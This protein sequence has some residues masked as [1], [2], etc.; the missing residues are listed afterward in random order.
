VRN[1]DNSTASTFQKNEYEL[2]SAQRTALVH[3]LETVVEDVVLVDAG[4]TVVCQ[5]PTLL[6]WVRS[7]DQEFAKEALRDVLAI[8]IKGRRNARTIELMGPPQHSLAIN[9]APVVGSDGASLGAVAIIQD[10]TQ[11]RYHEAVTSDF[12]ASVSHELKTPIGALGLLADAALMEDDRAVVRDL[13]ERMQ[14]ETQ[15]VSRVIDD[16]LNLSNAD[17]DDCVTLPVRTVVEKAMAGVH[18]LAEYRGIEVALDIEDELQIYGSMRHLKSA[19]HHLL[20]NAVKFSPR[21]STVALN[22]YSDCLWTEIAITNSGEGIPTEYLDRIFE[23]FF[24]VDAAH[25]REIDGSGLGLAIVRQVVQRH[26]GEVRVTSSSGQGTVFVVR[27]PA[28][29]DVITSRRVIEGGEDG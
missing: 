11:G 8:G 17:F 13:M 2:A 27:L 16:L 4:G 20:E 29:P 22:A 12:L 23:R 25:D 15:R 5:S 14:A 9:G 18:Y 1:Y 10:S 19:L 28:A 24:R 26:G 21:N 6:N 3:M 7:D